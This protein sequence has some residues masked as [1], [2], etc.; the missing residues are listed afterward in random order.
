MWLDRYAKHGLAGLLDRPRGA[1]REQV[2]AAV[3]ARVLAVS[4]QSPPAETE[5]CPT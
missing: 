2:P 3:R 4:K 1:G 5:V